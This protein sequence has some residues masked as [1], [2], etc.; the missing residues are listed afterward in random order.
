MLQVNMNEA[1][2][3]KKK[4]TILTTKNYPLEEIQLEH[5][6][7]FLKFKFYDKLEKHLTIRTNV[8]KE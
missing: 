6:N 5:R 7:Y 2:W 3:Q 4:L 8:P 1:D